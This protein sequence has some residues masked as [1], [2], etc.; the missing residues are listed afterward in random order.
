MII[1]YHYSQG[2]NEVSH[3]MLVT[4]DFPRLIYQCNYI[5]YLQWERLGDAVKQGQTPSI[6]RKDMS[7]DNNEELLQRLVWLE[8]H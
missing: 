1:F 2:S 7:N 6:K 5:G 8:R 4:A 3:C